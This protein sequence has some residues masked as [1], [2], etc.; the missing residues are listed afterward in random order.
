MLAENT[1]LRKIFLLDTPHLQVQSAFRVVYQNTK[2]K[3]VSVYHA[4]MF[5]AP[6]RYQTFLLG[7]PPLIVEQCPIGDFADLLAEV[8]ER[9]P[10][11]QIFW[12]S[13]CVTKSANVSRLHDG[14]LPWSTL[15]PLDD[16]VT[17]LRHHE[18]SVA[19]FPLNDAFL[20]VT[21]VVNGLANF[22]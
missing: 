15:L 8:G 4:D 21:R 14:G 10:V 2:H 18:T 3:V 11:V 17:H 5:R 9:F 6:L 1:A 16:A 19:A 12:L 7:G 13:R 20:P 22:V